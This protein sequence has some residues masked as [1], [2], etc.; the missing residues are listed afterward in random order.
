M[1]VIDRGTCDLPL[2]Q[3]GRKSSFFNAA[4]A[5]HVNQLSG[6]LHGIKSIRI[7]HLV[8]RTIQRTTQY[9]KIRARQERLQLV[10]R[11]HFIRSTIV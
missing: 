1:K 3:S 4:P 8:G 10:R 2:C 5:R 9:N 11:M 6:S 7:H